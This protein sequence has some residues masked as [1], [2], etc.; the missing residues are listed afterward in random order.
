[1]RQVARF[2]DMASQ[3]FGVTPQNDNGNRSYAPG[4]TSAWGQRTAG[5]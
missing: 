1:M 4:P 2:H 5:P 3:L